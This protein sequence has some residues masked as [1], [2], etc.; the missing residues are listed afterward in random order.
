MRYSIAYSKTEKFTFGNELENSY[1]D[2]VV[3]KPIL[4][5]FMEKMKYY[6][7]KNDVII[8]DVSYFNVLCEMFVNKEFSLKNLTLTRVMDILEEKVLNSRIIYYYE[9]NHQTD[10]FNSLPNTNNKIEDQ[11]IVEDSEESCEESSFYVENDNEESFPIEK[12][13][14]LNDDYINKYH[15]M[16]EEDKEV[17]SLYE[18]E[19]AEKNY[20]ILSEFKDFIMSF[21]KDI[22]Q[23]NK[24]EYDKFKVYLNILEKDMMF[25]KKTKINSLSKYRFSIGCSKKRSYY[26]NDTDA[27]GF[28][29]AGTCYYGDKIFMNSEFI[30]KKYGAI[31]FKKDIRHI[32]Y[33]EIG[34]AL[35]Y[36]YFKETVLRNIKIDKRSSYNEDFKNICIK[37]YNK[38]KILKSYIPKKYRKGFSYFINPKFNK[39]NFEDNIKTIDT[40][41]EQ[42]NN[43]YKNVFEEI[44]PPEQVV[45]QQKVF[46]TTIKKQDSI[47]DF[48]IPLAES[49]AESFAFL[50]SWI[51]NGFTE[52]DRFSIEAKASKERFFIKTQYNSMLYILENFDWTKLNIS[53]NVY[54]KR[55]V[56][57]KKY[58]KHIKDMPLITNKKVFRQIKSKKYI[59]YN[60]L[61]KNR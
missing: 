9:K 8:F 31:W 44:Y 11:N 56:Q 51:K 18:K 1:I 20:I 34:H 42:L 13:K 24:K 47:I 2:W 27:N 57:I 45:Y 55:K 58:L 43:D 15:E 32:F 6:K 54:L 61:L 3:N 30:N 48:A 40:F 29:P 35:D 5:K 49:W 41:S 23:S 46:S 36:L 14:E 38:F 33:H 52:Y 25:F 4:L 22:I 37:N 17:V 19:I 59:S 21:E 60:D 39:L 28:I 16:A 53:Y 12:N 26:G 10:E 50:F 7:P